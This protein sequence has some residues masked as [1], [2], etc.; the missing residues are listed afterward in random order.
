MLQ[1]MAVLC[2]IGSIKNGG[3]FMN[4]LLEKIVEECVDNTEVIVIDHNYKK[5]DD[6]F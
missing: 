4:I 5:D 1:Y 3:C 2:Y 6:L